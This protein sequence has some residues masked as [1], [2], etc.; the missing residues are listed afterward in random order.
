MSTSTS[1]GI[2]YAGIVVAI[3]IAIALAIRSMPGLA[4]A[5]SLPF[6][7]VLLVCPVAMFFMM[8]GMNS[9]PG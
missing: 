3:V 6:L 4:T 9:R 1:R 5:S 2:V 8:R 7:L